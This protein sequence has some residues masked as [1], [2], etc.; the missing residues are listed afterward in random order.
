MHTETMGTEGT[1]PRSARSKTR[2][3]RWRNLVNAP[4]LSCPFLFSKKRKVQVAQKKK[5]DL[6]CRRKLVF[7]GTCGFKSHS[8]RNKKILET[9]M[10]KKNKSPKLILITGPPAAG[11]TTVAN[12]LAKRFAKAIV[13]DENE[14]RLM[15]RKGFEAPRK[16]TREAKKQIRLVTQAAIFLAKLYS[17]AGFTVILTDVVISTKHLQQYAKPLRS[18]GFAAFG[19]LPNLATLRKRDRQ[20]PKLEQMG[21]RV[22]ELYRTCQKRKTNKIEWI[23]STRQTP[24]QTVEKILAKLKK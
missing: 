11:K 4:A 24:S 16:K 13:I 20:R 6:N 19:L 14:L 22:Q 17:N 7:L 3:Q 21:S 12:R 2:K 10:N 1:P 23:D 18:N 9:H 15:I 5:R 8:L